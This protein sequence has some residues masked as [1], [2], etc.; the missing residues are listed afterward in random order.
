MPKHNVMTMTF[1]NNDEGCWHFGR[2]SCVPHEQGEMGSRALLIG[3]EQLLGAQFAEQ[4]F[5]DVFVPR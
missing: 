2:T 4:L 5:Y 1:N 3:A